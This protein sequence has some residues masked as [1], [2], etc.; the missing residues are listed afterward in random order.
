MPELGEI[1]RQAREAKG[2]SLA[3]VEKAIKIRST[4]LQALEDGQYELLPAAVYIKG[5]LKNYAQFLGLDPQ[6]VLSLYQAPGVTTAAPFVPPM[7]N[8]PLEPASLRRWWR[9]GLL[10]LTIAALVI[11]WWGYQR[12]YGILPWAR[13]TAT[14][15]TRP[16]SIVTTAAT[17]PPTLPATATR[18]P[19]GTPTPTR[20]RT[21]T[22]TPVRLALGIEIVG[23]RSWVLVTADGQRVFAG[24]LEPGAADSWT[25]RERISLRSGNAGAVRVTLNG[26]DLGLFGGV[27][28]VVEVEWTAPGVPTRTPVPTP[29]T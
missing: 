28:E 18:A 14:P 23:S 29:T 5:F 12:Y 19:T 16:T 15:T 20:T 26:E 6:E 10:L 3:Q 11:A 22:P 8:E 13:P 27:G 9:V 4:Y 17:T 24:I 2:L 1:L 21:L 7:L 25:A